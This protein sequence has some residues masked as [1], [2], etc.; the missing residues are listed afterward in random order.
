M[1]EHARHGIGQGQGLDLAGLIAGSQILEQE[2]VIAWLDADDVAG[3]GRAEVAQVRGVGGQGVLDDDDREVGML[4]AEL[5]EPAAGGIP[6]AVVLGL[7]VLLDNGLRGQRDDLLEVGMDLG[8]T[9]EE[10]P[11]FYAIPIIRITL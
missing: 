3:A 6:L 9:H 1:M 4:L 5:F 10:N 8:F 2:R 7:A 11:R